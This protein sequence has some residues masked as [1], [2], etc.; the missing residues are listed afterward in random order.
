MGHTGGGAIRILWDLLQGSAADF[1]PYQV[2]SLCRGR[3]VTLCVNLYERA[4]LK[5][6]T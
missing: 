6:N 3:I 1:G 5:S 4:V 2:T